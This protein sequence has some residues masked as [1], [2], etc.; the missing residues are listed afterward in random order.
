VIPFTYDTLRE[1]LEWASKQDECF[2][3]Y[4]YLEGDDSVSIDGDVTRKQFEEWVALR[5][6]Q[7]T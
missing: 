5:T 4:L 3:P 1:F 7:L 6:Q 2:A